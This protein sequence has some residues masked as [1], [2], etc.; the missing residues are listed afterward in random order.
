LDSEIEGLNL[1][2]EQQVLSNQEKT[3]RR[4]LC[5]KIE[6]IWR[7]EEIKARQRSRDGDIKEGERNTTFFYQS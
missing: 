2:A 5:L 4:E 7:I 3:I 6:Q 1:L